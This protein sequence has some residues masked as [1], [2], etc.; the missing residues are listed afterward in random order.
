[1]RSKVSAFRILNLTFNIIGAELGGEQLPSYHEFVKSW[2]IKSYPSV[3][4]EFLLRYIR[5]IQKVS[6]K[7]LVCMLEAEK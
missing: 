6:L 3:H 4:L 7:T 2:D 5:V 1:M